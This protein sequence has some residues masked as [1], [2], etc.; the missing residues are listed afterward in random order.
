MQVRSS[1]LFDQGVF[2][3]VSRRTQYVVDDRTG[4]RLLRPSSVFDGARIRIRT[5]SLGLRSPEPLAVRPADS[6]RIAIVGASTV[7]GVDAAANEDTFPALLEARLRK[8]LPGRSIEVINAG[9]A[10]Y[11]LDDERRMLE[12]VVLPLKPD[13]VV[14]YTG[15]NDF[16]EY[17]LPSSEPWKPRTTAQRH[18]LPVVALP[19]WLLSAKAM[20]EVSVLLGVRSVSS[21]EA[22]DPYSVD[23][24]PYR[25]RLEALARTVLASGTRLVLATNVKAFRREQPVREQE[26]LLG[27]ARF[28]TPCFD[29][30]GLNALYDLHNAAIRHLGKRMNL[31]VLLLDQIIPG[32]ERYFASSGFLSHFSSEGDQLVADELF[33]FLQEQ[34][35]VRF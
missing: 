29:V 2:N 18:G 10:G 6:L 20:L 9:I 28:F 17:C 7:M 22:R 3:V 15:V 13:L 1:L 27:A 23:M 25:R 21:G 26:R 8:A 32:G 31:P 30:A 35:L 14:A 19:E 33:R 34:K 12:A 4:L 24:R 16:Q 5:N 11:R